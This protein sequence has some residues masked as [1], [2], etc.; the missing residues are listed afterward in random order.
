MSTD[1]F[2]EKSFR[3]SPWL[4][5]IIPRGSRK[6]STG[7]GMGV[8]VL[9]TESS[10][11]VAVFPSSLAAHLAGC[12]NPWG[13]CVHCRHRVVVLLVCLLVWFGL[14][15]L[16]WLLVCR[17]LP[18]HLYTKLSGMALR[19]SLE[20]SEV[21]G[22]VWA[23]SPSSPLEQSILGQDFF[24]GLIQECV[25][26]LV[27]SG[28]VARCPGGSGIQPGLGRTFA[29]SRIPSGGGSGGLGV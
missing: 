14:H 28:G 21:F 4:L 2:C 26:H 17:P 5:Y 25:E 29:F 8:G 10:L 20:R 11:S 12:L 18:A 6:E 27:V 15:P 7:P 3:E 19:H 1:L 22:K 24:S 13:Q 16:V 9:N 23:P